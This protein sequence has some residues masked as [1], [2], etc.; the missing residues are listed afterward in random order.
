MGWEKRGNNEYY[1]Q[2][3]RIDGRIKSVYVGQGEL[4][5]LIA[6]YDQI[7]S[8][9]MELERINKNREKEEFQELNNFI[10]EISEINKDLVDALFIINGYHQ[11]KR[12]WRKKRK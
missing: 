7:N 2:K 4:A 8:T 11:H 5:Y 12:Q 1:Y 3:E 6:R 9:K 10:D